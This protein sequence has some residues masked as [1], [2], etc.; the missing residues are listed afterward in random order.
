MALLLER[1]LEPGSGTPVAPPHQGQ[2][3][4]LD[5]AATSRQFSTE[6]KSS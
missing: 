4:Y 3:D 2:E 1:N 5:R 6:S